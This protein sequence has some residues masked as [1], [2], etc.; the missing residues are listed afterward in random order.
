[1]HDRTYDAGI[2]IMT[3]IS[4]LIGG[5]WKPII[6]FL[7]QNNVNRFG[8]LKKCMPKISK[9]VLTHLLRELEKDE[10]ISRSVVEKTA[11][12]VV[13]YHLTEK[14]I[15]TR[16]LIDNMIQWGLIYFRNDYPEGVLDD[17]VPQ[18]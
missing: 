5:K 10:L 3:K 9:K 1:M 14:G 12:Q 2:C 7:I 4:H 16:Q 11:P 15:S 18:G 17:S 13:I 8:V 6:L